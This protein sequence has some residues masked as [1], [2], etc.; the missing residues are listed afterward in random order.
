[1][2]YPPL[3]LSGLSPE[4]VA[5]PYFSPAVRNWTTAEISLD[6]PAILVRNYQSFET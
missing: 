1:M 5:K 3:S 2:R 6:T 4:L